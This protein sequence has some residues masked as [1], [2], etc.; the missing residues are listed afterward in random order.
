MSLTFRFIQCF[1]P[2][3]TYKKLHLTILQYLF[4]S[5]TLLSENKQNQCYS[6]LSWPTLVSL[7]A[8]NCYNTSQ[9]QWWIRYKVHRISHSLSYH[10]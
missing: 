10:L 8:S 5:A 1:Y 7:H 4:P 2:S 6:T 3:T 9:H